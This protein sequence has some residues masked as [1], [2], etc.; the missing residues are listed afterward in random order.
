MLEASS[1]SPV[2][3][4][5]LRKQNVRGVSALRGTGV[6]LGRAWLGHQEGHHLRLCQDPELRIC[7][8]FLAEK[9]TQQTLKL[10]L[11]EDPRSHP[12]S[13]GLKFCSDD[14]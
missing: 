12:Y 4:Q 8:G 2:S 9:G 13:E 1:W 14:A 7:G 6:H 5:R 3:S 11:W 10:I